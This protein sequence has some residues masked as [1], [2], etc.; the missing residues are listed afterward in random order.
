MRR[1]MKDIRLGE[2]C[3]YLGDARIVIKAKIDQLKQQS[4]KQKGMGAMR[5]LPHH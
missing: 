2:G 5:P 3:R 4:F 1:F